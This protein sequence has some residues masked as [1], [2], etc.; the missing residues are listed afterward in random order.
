MT[1]NVTG[2]EAMTSSRWTRVLD[3]YA[4]ELDKLT[5]FPP[6]TALGN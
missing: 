3:D 5:L 2:T 1:F 4:H 6:A